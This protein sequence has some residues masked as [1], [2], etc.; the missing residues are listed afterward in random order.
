MTHH[1]NYNDSSIITLSQNDHIRMR[2]TMYI[3]SVGELGVYKSALEIITNSVDEFISGYGKEIIVDIDTKN[4]IISVRDFA[5]GIPIGK[6]E[7][8]LT[9][10]GS[11]GKFN[12]D[13]YK[14]SAGLNG[15]GSTIVVALS[16]FFIAEVWRD[17][18]YARIEFNK[19]IK[20]SSTVEDYNN[21]D[22][23]GTK[24]TFKPDIDIFETVSFPKERYKKCLLNFSYI[25]PGLKTT[26]IYDGIKESF[27]SENGIIDYYNLILKNKKI[28]PISKEPIHVID[29]GFN[30]Q[31]VD[32][33]FTVEAYFN[34]SEDLSS[35]YI[36]SYINGLEMTQHGTH[37]EGFK[38]A[39]TQA[40][41]FYINKNNLLPKNAKF[42]IDGDCVRENLIALIVAQHSNPKFSTQVKDQ[43]TNKD[44]L[45]FVKS[46]TY[47]IFSQW[48]EN[49]PKEANNICKIV[50]RSARAKAAA[51][52]AKENIIKSGGKLNSL[53]KIDPKKFSD[54]KSN[55]P[56]ISELFIVEG[57]SA[58]GS[59]RQARNSDNQAIYKLRGKIQNVIGKQDKALSEEL[60]QLIEILGCGIGETFNIKKLRFHKIIFS[61]DADSDGYHISSL[62]AGFFYTYYKPLITAGY[63]YAS[64]PPLYQLVIN[65][66]SIFI[67]NMKYF[68]LAISTIAKNAFYLIDRN[69][70]FILSDKLFDVYLENLNGYKE[71][72]DNFVIQT[73][74]EPNLLERIILNYHTI[75]N[76]NFK[77][78]E[79]FNYHTTIKYDN[80]DGLHI[81]IDRDYEHYF[82]IL[83]NEFY[84]NVYEPV[85]KRL[86][87]IYLMDVKLKGKRTSKIYGGT[88]YI[89]AVILNNILLGKNVEVHRL[90]GLGE[91]RAEDLKYFLF[92]ENTRSIVQLTM[93][94]IEETAKELDIYLGKNIEEK[95]LLF[96]I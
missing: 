63:I 53:T 83:D 51:K 79:N 35:E 48:L 75:S 93:R 55:D 32:S 25:N 38:S 17:N 71:F 87:Q 91:V 76:K 16:E 42:K 8:I 58:G 7:E 67:P 56:E 62:L 43:L 45:T 94:D 57:D 30:E 18:K 12:S 78:L 37:V 96:D 33:K 90:K 95:K 24:I 82:I 65:K 22:D 66:K 69:N 15:S 5:R 81:E 72:L 54:C 3:G 14:F 13:N 20:V 44:I 26:L 10:I 49:N 77:S 92:N 28:R 19:G 70:K 74:T 4:N 59:A 31:H 61:A 46:S 86:N 68:K 39:I 84:K 36:Q 88:P 11:G 9:H 29:K 52:E 60:K 47:R 2:P 50:I 34:W 85:I 23:T 41:N 89:N 6:L 27:Y 40:L 1:H 73:N 21:E 80:L 64:K